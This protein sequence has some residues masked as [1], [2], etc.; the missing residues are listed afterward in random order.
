MQHRIDSSLL[1]KDEM[2]ALES[3]VQ[4]G[5]LPALI[6]D[7]G[8]H[9]KLPKPIFELLVHLV[10]Q[11]KQGRSIVMMPED[12]AFTTQAAANF[13]GVSR[14]HFVNLIEEGKIP[15]HKVGTHRRVYFRDLKEYSERRDK[16]RRES[17]DSLFDKVS[18]AGKH[19]SSYTGD[20][21]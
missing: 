21:S 17:L 15:Y 18:K 19:D 20:E 4:S 8:N 5:Q 2:Q 9:I 3:L 1:N 13:L 6:D 11:M 7:E 12:E 16:S 10:Q 14:Q